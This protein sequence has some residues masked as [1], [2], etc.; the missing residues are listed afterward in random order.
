MVREDVGGGLG[1]VTPFQPCR[2]SLPSAHMSLCKV[3]FSDFFSCKSSLFK[4]THVAF[5]GVF[6]FFFLV[7]CKTRPSSVRGLMISTYSKEAHP[8]GSCSYLLSARG[9]CVAFQLHSS[10]CLRCPHWLLKVCLMHIKLYGNEASIAQTWTLT[11]N[12]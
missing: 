2:G 4:K 10:G 5:S 11:F 1:V 9:P 8:L 7:L 3:A 12:P 6:F